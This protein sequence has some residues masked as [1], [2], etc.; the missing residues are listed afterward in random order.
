MYDH[1]WDGL[2]ADA[3]AAIRF[4][5]REQPGVDQNYTYHVDRGQF[6]SCCCSTRTSSAPAVYEGVRVS[7]GRLPRAEHRDRQFTM[8]RRKLGV[9]VKMVVDASGRH[10][11][12]GN[13]LKLKVNDPVFDQYAHPHLVRAA[14][15]AARSRSTGST[16]TTSTSTSCR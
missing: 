4:D 10:T 11:L 3:H 5:E 8:G 7:A 9:S 13:Q 15:I 6:D 14:T 2:D 1:D 16:A 12:L